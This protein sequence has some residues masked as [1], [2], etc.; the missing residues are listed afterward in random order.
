MTALEFGVFM[1]F[2]LI[3]ASALWCEESYS[4]AKPSIPS[5]KKGRTYLGTCTEERGHRQK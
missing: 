4:V 5:R 1:T 2:L 3:G